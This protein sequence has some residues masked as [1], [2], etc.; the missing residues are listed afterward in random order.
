MIVSVSAQRPASA[1]APPPPLSLH[2]RLRR[3]LSILPSGYGRPP[4]LR[5]SVEDHLAGDDQRPQDRVP[6]CFDLD[7]QG[8]MNSSCGTFLLFR[9]R[10]NNIENP[11]KPAQKRCSAAA[12]AETKLGALWSGARRWNGTERCPSDA[13]RGAGR[14][15]R[16]PCQHS[17]PSSMTSTLQLS[18]PS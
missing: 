4:A 14:H 2:S 1:T 12:G 5:R 18:M 10:V 17:T 11:S 13:G 16:Q 6:G 7:E 9:Q 3:V 15:S 8:S